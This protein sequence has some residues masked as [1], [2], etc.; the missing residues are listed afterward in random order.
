M[1]LIYLKSNEEQIESKTENKLS[2]IYNA[3]R[4][5]YTN[6]YDG[7]IK[8]CTKAIELDQYYCDA[9]IIRFIANFESNK[10]KEAAIDCLIA[11]HIEKNIK[12]LNP[13]YYMGYILKEYLNETTSLKRK[14]FKKEMENLFHNKIKI[15]K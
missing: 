4:I 10:L 14:N 7:V 11:F 8:L 1:E 9:Y 3:K 12:Q 15:C 13:N 5:L 6:H 2:I